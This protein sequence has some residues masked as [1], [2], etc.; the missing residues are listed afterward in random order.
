LEKANAKWND[1]DA[2]EAILQV[3]AAS[4]WD[5]E[6]LAKNLRQRAGC[7]FT[8]RPKAP[9]LMRENIGGSRPTPMPRTG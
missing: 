9:K 8:R 3:P 5:D 2:A 4:L 7:G 1:P 6:R